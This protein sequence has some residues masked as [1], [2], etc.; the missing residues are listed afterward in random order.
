MTTSTHGST[1]VLVPGIHTSRECIQSRECTGPTAVQGVDTLPVLVTSV[2]FHLHMDTYYGE[3]LVRDTCWNCTV[4]L[5]KT[6]SRSI[7]YQE[8]PDQKNLHRKLEVQQD[9][10]EIRFPGTKHRVFSIMFFWS[11]SPRVANKTSRQNQYLA[12]LLP[13][14]QISMLYQKLVRL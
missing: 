10:Q 6:L 8:N 12:R 5:A 7:F 4:T 3:M 13:N 2:L 1:R 11:K 14:F 9:I